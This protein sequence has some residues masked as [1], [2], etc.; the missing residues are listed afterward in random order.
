MNIK[1][2]AAKKIAIYAIGNYLYTVMNSIANIFTSRILGPTSTGAINYFNAITTNVDS[3]IYGTIRSSVEREVPQIEEKENKR[4]FAENS[5][6][7]NFHISIIISIIYFSIGIFSDDNLIK[8]SAFYVSILNIIKCL[9][10]FY[11]IWN[12]SLNRIE[13]VSWVMIITSLILPILIIFCST[14]LGLKGFWIGRIILQLI[15]LFLY[16]YLYKSLF[17][18]IK[19]DIKFILSIIKSGG[20]IVLFSLFVS[21]FQ[22]IDKFIIKETLGLEQLGYYSIG[23]M[24]FTM[25][26]LIP[27][28]IIGAIYPQFVGLG[29]KYL[30]PQILKYSLGIEVL[31]IICCLITAI[32]T[33]IFIKFI[34]PQYMRSIPIVYIFF[35]AF[36]CY[37]SV[38]LKYID[39][40]RKKKIKL[41]IQ[42][43]SLSLF[44]TLFLFLFS[45]TYI[46]SLSSIA[47]ISVIGFL[48][49]S[50][51]V[52]VSWCIIYKIKGW[53]FIW[54]IF[55]TFIPLIILSP[56]YLLQISIIYFIFI[57]L[58][59]LFIFYIIRYLIEEYY[60]I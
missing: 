34:L 14:R 30:K 54:I 41:L 55:S 45:S 44:I 59:L 43:S 58:V 20:G 29:E 47:W 27:S 9:S 50:L 22:T 8:Y 33:P 51:S 37:S 52:N 7:L 35:M 18:I 17:K 42:S 24:V 46:T 56:L 25:L 15:S 5:F 49:L 11:R 4:I 6:S 53:H 19:I 23:T 39:I 38:Q 2:N 13:A 57:S 40:I 32:F 26:M 16:Y 3:V 36:V 48:L 1:K 31:S 10:D 12:K 21:L 28:S 60:Q